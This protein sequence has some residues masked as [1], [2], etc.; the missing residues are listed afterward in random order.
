M[1]CTLSSALAGLA[2]GRIRKGSNDRGIAQ[3]KLKNI[4]ITSFE[5]IHTHFRNT[6][7]VFLAHAGFPWPSVRAGNYPVHSSFRPGTLSV[8][9]IQTNDLSSPTFSLACCVRGTRFSFVESIPTGKRAC[10]MIGHCM[11]GTGFC[12]R[13]TQPHREPPKWQTSSQSPTSLRHGPL[14]RRRL[15]YHALRTSARRARA[16]PFGKAGRR[17]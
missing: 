4:N 17:K 8:A 11:C 13:R 5:V 14:V 7:R 2:G 15:E 1:R 9:S 6:E 16:A 12:I 10:V 3:K